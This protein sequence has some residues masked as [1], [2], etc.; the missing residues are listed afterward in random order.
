L[1]NA[2][3]NFN[4]FSMIKSIRRIGSGRTKGAVSFCAMKKEQ[5]N[6]MLRRFPKNGVV[7]FSRLWLESM[8]EMGFDTSAAR[9]VKKVS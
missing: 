9:R 6:K 8:K 7:V 4:V 5:F 3:E 2:Q 1:T